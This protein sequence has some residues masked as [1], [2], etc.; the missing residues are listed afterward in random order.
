MDLGRPQE[1]WAGTVGPLLEAIA[2]RAVWAPGEDELTTLVRI[3]AGE[4]GFQL[5]AS[6]DELT[7]AVV[8][9]GDPNY[10]FVSSCL[11][12]A[13]APGVGG[14]LGPPVIVVSAT[15]WPHGDRDGYRNPDS[16]P[17]AHRRAYARCLPDPDQAWLSAEPAQIAF[18]LEPGGAGNGVRTAVELL[19]ASGGWKTRLLEGFGG[20]A[21]LAPDVRL[22]STRKLTR[23]W[24][25]LGDEAAQAL[26]LGLD[27]ELGR[28][29]LARAQLE[30]ALAEEVARGRAVSADLARAL[31]ALDQRLVT[32]TEAVQSLSHD[33][34]RVDTKLHAGVQREQRLEHRLTATEALASAART[35]LMDERRWIAEQAGVVA[36]SQSWRVGH[37]L[38]RAVWMLT[39]RRVRSEDA[40]QRIITRME[41]GLG[42]GS[43]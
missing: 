10:Y 26:L 19:V 9:S 21:I 39:F 29:A 14:D 35:E 38:A 1:H 34:A 31:D 8:I 15:G 5:S 41:R 13:V 4:R 2:P 23:I 28:A 40:L 33:L 30:Q 18:A 25:R 12:A 3:H 24:K 11:E 37:R 7:D 43:S 36:R 6:P 32:E 42:S 17:P 22:E 16:V 20:V 27:L